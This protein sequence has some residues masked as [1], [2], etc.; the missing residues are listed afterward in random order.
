MRFQLVDRIVA[1]KRG[2]SVSAVKNLTMADEYLADHFPGFPVMP[3]VLMLETLVQA[4]AWLM[5][6]AEDFRYSTI[7]LKEAKALKFNSF[8]SPGRTL[9]VESAVQKRDGNIWTFKATSTVDGATGVS[10][11]LVLEQFNLSDRN[12]KLA[13][14]DQRR[15]EGLR[16]QFAQIWPGSAS[17]TT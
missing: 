6:D 7:L 15:I 13:E 11:R 9:E 16:S 1:L 4:S 12:P 5:R 17:S 3:G 14:S 10:G 2:E 8:V